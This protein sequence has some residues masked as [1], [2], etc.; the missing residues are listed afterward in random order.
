MLHFALETAV[1]ANVD[2]V[3]ADGA[4][5]SIAQTLAWSTSAQWAHTLLNKAATS[6]GLF[7]EF[8]R[9]LALQINQYGDQ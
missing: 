4:Y 2:C 8:V 9:I 3:I 5:H 6:C 1:D 7:R